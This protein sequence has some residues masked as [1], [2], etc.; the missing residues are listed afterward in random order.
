M[1]IVKVITY[2]EAHHIFA[3]I[4]YQLTTEKT[5]LFLYNFW[6]WCIDLKNIWTQQLVVD[7]IVPC[8]FWVEMMLENY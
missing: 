7:V 4:K 3:G 2:K 5:D 6:R 8:A 1:D